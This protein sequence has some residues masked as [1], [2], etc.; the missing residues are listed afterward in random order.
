MEVEVVEELT[1]V[2]MCS[3]C[4]PLPLGI[5]RK[6][7]WADMSERVYRPGLEGIQGSIKAAGVGFGGSA[8]LATRTAKANIILVPPRSV[9]LPAHSYLSYLP[10]LAMTIG[11]G[12]TPEH[13]WPPHFPQQFPIAKSNM[14]MVPYN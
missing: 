14:F 12:N 3:W 2:L 1:L 11:S 10:S 13:G 6:G 4:F 7:G 8:R 5:G 9:D